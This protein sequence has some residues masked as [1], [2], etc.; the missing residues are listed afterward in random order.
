MA[1][2]GGMHFELRRA[3]MASLANVIS[4]NLGRPVAD[5]TGIQ[6]NYEIPLTFS[7]EGLAESHR[8]MIARVERDQAAK[9]QAGGPAPDSTPMPSIFQAVEQL[10]L[11]LEPRKVPV[12]YII[13]DKAEK[14]PT[15]N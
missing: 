8:M 3:T 2:P 13:V 10:G 4:T 5:M 7:G 14:V 9:A 6:G 1:V 15:E 12:E 11:K